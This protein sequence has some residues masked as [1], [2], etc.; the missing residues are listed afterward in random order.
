MFDAYTIKKVLPRLVIAV[1]LIQL[2][3]PLI[4]TLINVINQ[5]SWGL[6]GLMYLPFGGRDALDIGVTLEKAG[7]GGIFAGLLLG[8]GVS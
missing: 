3:W 2:S 8:G 6:E 4:T 7:G 1:I 5:V